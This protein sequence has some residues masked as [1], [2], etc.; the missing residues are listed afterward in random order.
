[1]NKAKNI[2]EYETRHNSTDCREGKGITVGIIDTIINQCR[3]IKGRDLNSFEVKEALLD[4]FHDDDFSYLLYQ[5]NEV[6]R[7][8][9]GDES[10]EQ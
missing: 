5:V 8:S 4:L 1:M 10:N 9:K 3:L 6:G 2:H 7:L